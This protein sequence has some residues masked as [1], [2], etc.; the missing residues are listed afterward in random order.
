MNDR[1]RKSGR[2]VSTPLSGVGSMLPDE[3]RQMERRR[4]LIEQQGHRH[5]ARV[6]ARSHDADFRDDNAL[7]NDM[8]EKMQNS[9]EQNPWLDTQR[10][11][12]IDIQNMNPDNLS[13]EARREYDNER[14]N[15]EQEKQHRLGLALGYSKAPKPQGP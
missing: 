3:T 15:Q 1:I 11:D 10:L 2:D 4:R 5:L 6:N 13:P 14:R 8:G 7:S 9:I 12:G